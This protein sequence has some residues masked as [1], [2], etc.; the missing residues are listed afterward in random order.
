MKQQKSKAQQIC[1]LYWQGWFVWQIA[2]E[3]DV[4]EAEVVATLGL[5]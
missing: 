1:E 4:T 2:R 3:L 5:G